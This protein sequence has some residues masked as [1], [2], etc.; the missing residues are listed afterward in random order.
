MTRLVA[1]ARGAPS[2]AVAR[3]CCFRP[4]PRPFSRR[5]SRLTC[6]CPRRRTCCER[7]RRKRKRRA[8]TPRRGEES[9]QGSA[10][11]RKIHNKV[12][13]SWLVEWPGFLVFRSLLARLQQ[14]GPEASPPL[15]TT[16]YKN[17]VQYELHLQ[18][19]STARWENESEKASQEA[20][21]G[22]RC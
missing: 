1:S 14:A 12:F 17:E 21:A 16:T 6:S 20:G 3:V 18:R 10:D 5:D 7:A 9:T 13:L 8:E 2:P 4:T 15:R 19:R 11:D 22:G